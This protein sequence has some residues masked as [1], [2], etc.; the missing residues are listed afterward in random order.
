M[1]KRMTTHK[2]KTHKK[3]NILSENF[4]LPSITNVQQPMD[5]ITLGKSCKYVRPATLSITQ[6]SLMQIPLTAKCWWSFL[7]DGRNEKE[8]IYKLVWFMTALS[9]S[10]SWLDRRCVVY[11]LIVD[12]LFMTGS[13]MC[14][15]WLA[16][17]C[18]VHDW[19]VDVLFMTGSTF[20]Y[21]TFSTYVI[22]VK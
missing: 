4:S 8:A 19:T 9:M 7:C 20:I 12:E 2:K 22:H 1:K 11:D 15:S 5:N 17:R 3:N 6:R 14:C 10:C 13:S 16:R 18:V 21:D